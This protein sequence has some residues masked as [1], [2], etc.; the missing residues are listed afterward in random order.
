MPCY[1]WSDLHGEPRLIG[2]T[3]LVGAVGEF[4]YAPAHIAAG[5]HSIDPINLPTDP[6]AFTT[7]AN[8]GVFG[9]LADAGPDAWGK[10]VLMALH[11]RGMASAGPLEILL[12]TRGHG[13]GAL[14]FSASRA[15]VQWREPGIPLAKLGA[16]AEAS[17]AIEMG[18]V[19][20]EQLRQL[21]QAG[22]SL[23]GVHPKI[24]VVDPQGVDW[25][26]KF[27]GREDIVD[28]PA[29][30]WASMRLARA[31]GC[32]VAEV[33]LT[34]VGERR[35][36][37]VKRF[38]RAAGRTLHYASAH[39]LWNRASA[40]E[41]DALEWA[42]YAGIAALRKRLPGEGVREDVAELFRRMVFN[43]AIGNTDDHG[44]N[45]GFV[46]NA[47]GQWRLAPAFDVLPTLGAAANQQAL[48]VGPRGRERSFEN[49]LEGAA[50]FGLNLK[51]ARTLIIR[52]C[53]RID[54]RFAGLL[55]EA[56]AAPADAEA[57]LARRLRRPS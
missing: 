37:L 12:M 57:A 31:C 50:H 3:E 43:V 21:V 27:R 34:A 11:P 30:E 18:T 19:L 20:R 25:I 48:G 10:R 4:R 56:G 15:D 22:T 40:S 54:L 45:H 41:A 51:S 14:L 47:A 44:R 29:I 49:V 39:A 32:S 8:K 55:R 5:G 24:A 35:A 36:L 52:I 6:A 42:S 7:R 26:A 23:G 2:A 53:K 13:T 38:E 9:V 33:A 28:T 17:Q 16:A 1:V 46:M